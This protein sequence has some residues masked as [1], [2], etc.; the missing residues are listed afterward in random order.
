[1][2]TGAGT[3]E[4]LGALVGQAPPPKVFISARL[5]GPN[6]SG[7]PEK[8]RSFTYLTY[9][10]RD[11][12]EEFQYSKYANSLLTGIT[13]H[14]AETRVSTRT[15]TMLQIFQTALMDMD[16]NTYRD[17][18]LDRIGM[19]RDQ[20]LPDYLRLNFGPGQRYAAKGCYIM[21]L[22]PGH[23]APLLR[24]SDWVID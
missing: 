7:V 11:P 17:N 1:L 22:G 14:R 10:Y 15:Y 16:R 18:L 13:K 9:P 5:V 24:K 2:W 20:F 3:F 6:L 19:Q 4:G 8:A 21:Q 12:K 23:E